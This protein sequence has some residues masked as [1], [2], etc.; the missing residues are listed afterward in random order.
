MEEIVEATPESRAFLDS[1]GAR[2]LAIIV[3]IVAATLLFMVH[4]RYEG[5]SSGMLSGVKKSAF[6][7]CVDERMAAFEKLAD[8]AGYSEERRAA[9]QKAAQ[10]SANVVCA[11]QARPEAK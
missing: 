9:A 5:S 6:S 4:D 8:Q 11:E 1:I 7:A 2:A 3:A 10:A